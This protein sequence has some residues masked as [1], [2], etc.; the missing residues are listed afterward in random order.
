MSRRHTVCAL[1]PFSLDILEQRDNLCVCV[2]FMCVCVSRLTLNNLPA[3][4]LPQLA[5]ESSWW[6]MGNGTCNSISIQIKDFLSLLLKPGEITHT[7]SPFSPLSLSHTHP[8]VFKTNNRQLPRTWSAS[9]SNYR[10]QSSSRL[11]FYF[12]SFMWVGQ[13]FKARTETS[14]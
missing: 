7:L 9:N 4:C 6:I 2:Y 12:S 10:V 1:V 5:R 3:P 14:A 8:S 11:F 13:A